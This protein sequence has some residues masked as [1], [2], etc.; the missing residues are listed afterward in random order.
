[1]SEELANHHKTDY[2]SRTGALDNAIHQIAFDVRHHLSTVQSAIELIEITSDE[3]VRISSIQLAKE[4][5]RA[6]LE[7][8]NIDLDNII[9]ARVRREEPK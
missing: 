8:V 4:S 6:I 5:I 1:M 7:I 2:D 3:D 9:R